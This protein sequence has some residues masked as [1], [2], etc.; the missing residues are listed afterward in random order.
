M[1]TII[2]DIT[3]ARPVDDVLW[4]DADYRAVFAEAGLEVQDVWRPLAHGDEPFV[5][6]NETR[7]APWTIYVLRSLRSQTIPPSTKSLR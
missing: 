4:P 1:R 5:W 7:I 6:V 3:D 2:T